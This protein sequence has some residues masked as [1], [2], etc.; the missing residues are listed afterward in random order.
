MQTRNQNTM[1][2]VVNFEVPSTIAEFAEAAGVSAEQAEAIVLK[3]ALDEGMFRT[4]LPE[5]RKTFFERL[6]E[7]TG[8]AR[9]QIGTVEKVVDGEKT[10]VPVYQKDTEYFKAVQAQEGKE[11]T[12][13]EDLANS[14]AAETL[15]DLK[16]KPRAGKVGKEFVTR[17]NA[18]A[19]AVEAGRTTW[20]KFIKKIQ[21]LNPGITIE[22]GEDGTPD[23]DSVARALKADATRRAAEQTDDFTE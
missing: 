22:N 11:A 13:Y 17:A 1:G 19:S 23:L 6:E 8:I 18:V 4:V 2:M 14:V 16:S 20:E 15:F 7:E 21:S 10:D 9:A 5:F 3:Y 12:D